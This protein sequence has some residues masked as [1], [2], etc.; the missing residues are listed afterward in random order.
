MLFLLAAGTAG[1]VQAAQGVE[2]ELLLAV[3][4]LP[5]VCVTLLRLAALW[6]LRGS[7]APRPVT[8]DVRGP[9]IFWPSYTLLVP[10]Y[11]EAE[12]VP[13]LV[14]ALARLDYPVARLQILLLAE[15]DDAETQAA[16]WKAARPAHMSVLVVPRGKPRTKPRALNY[17]LTFATGD[18]VAV[19]DAEDA[20]DPGQLKAVV[21]AYRSATGRLGCIQARLDVYN[22][23]QS[24]FSR[25][26]AL[27]YAALFAGLLPA[28]A[29][30][31]LPLPLGGTSNHFPRKVLMTAGAWDPYNVTEDADLG[32]RLARLGFKTAV[33]S[34]TTWEEAPVTARQWFGQRMRWIKGWM[35]TYLVH[36]RNPVSLVRDLG[37][38]GFLGFQLIFGGLIFSALCHPILY[39]ALGSKLTSGSPVLPPASA[40]GGALVALCITNIL[41]SYLSTMAL[42]YVCA[43]RRRRRLV[44][45]VLALPIYWL[46]ISLA[47]YAALLEL[48]FRPHHWRKTRHTGAGRN[49]VERALEVQR[50]QTRPR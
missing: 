45:S 41:L 32:L 46:L 4:T 36:M 33:I 49:R 30:F 5:F 31:G 47:A 25:Q 8:P 20:P 50:R 11:R 43:G 19:F 35:Q 26:F 17:G 44:L 48:A 27:E 21:R 9:D 14:K 16:L 38:K 18:M 42:A 28:Y 7:P 40:S 24:F 22:P 34:A 39:Y 10:L 37:F 3:C 12:V 23:F 29:H 15:E 2:R 13:A 1:V 6:R